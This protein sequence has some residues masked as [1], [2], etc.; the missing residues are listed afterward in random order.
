VRADRRR[1]PAFSHGAIESRCAAGAK[2][3][4]EQIE[5]R[6][7]GMCRAGRSPT[8]RE[9]RLPD[10]ARPFAIPES[11]DAFFRRTWLPLRLTGRER[12]VLV[13]HELEGGVR[14]HI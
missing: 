12:A 2:H 14:V 1:E 9:L 13:V 8:E 4:G 6:C 5:R 10:V 3:C 11:A 7:I